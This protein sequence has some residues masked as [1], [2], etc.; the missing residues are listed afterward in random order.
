MRVYPELVT[1][2]HG[3]HH[4]EYRSSTPSKS[5]WLQ[6]LFIEFFPGYLALWLSLR[7]LTSL[8]S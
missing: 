7:T 5:V 2:Q 4:A 6:P 3:P 8:A 1:V